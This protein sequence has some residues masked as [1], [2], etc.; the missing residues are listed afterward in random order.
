MWQDILAALALVLV[1]EG[2]TPFL[3]PG[4]SRRMMLMVSQLPDR[5][6]RIAGLSAMAAGAVLLYLVRHA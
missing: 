6:L 5:T 3:N 2:L 4:A 1:I